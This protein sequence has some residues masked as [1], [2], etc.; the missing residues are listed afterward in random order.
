MGNV[1]LWNSE[2]IQAS[3]PTRLYR[4]S[5][6]NS[7][8]MAWC[9]DLMVDGKE[10]YEVDPASNMDAL[11]GNKDFLDQSG[12]RVCLLRLTDKVKLYWGS[13]LQLRVCVQFGRAREPLRAS[14]EAGR[15]KSSLMEEQ[16]MSP[17]DCLRARK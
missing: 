16:C 4:G 3:K 2:I 7:R 8:Q 12:E 9:K 10:A 15:W 6:R 5:F 11:L 13:D 14:M 1:N 17:I